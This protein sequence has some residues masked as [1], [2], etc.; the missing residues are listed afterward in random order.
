VESDA[1]YI[2]KTSAAALESIKMIA[3][4]KQVGEDSVRQ[5]TILN[6]IEFFK[7]K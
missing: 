4:I 2:G 3:E 6:T 5:Q 1:P 7:I